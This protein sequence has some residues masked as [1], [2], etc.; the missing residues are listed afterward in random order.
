MSE[1]IDQTLTPIKAEPGQSSIPLLATK[2]YAPPP[3]PNLVPRI[4]LTR[5]LAEGLQLGC[6]LT[7]VS[8]PAGFG[9]TTLVTEWLNGQAREQGSKGAEENSLAL[10]S[11]HPSTLAQVAWLSLDDEDNDAIRFLTYLIAASQRLD[12]SIGQ[13]L[14]HSRQLPPSEALVTLLV[15]DLAAIPHTFALVLDDYHVIK[16]ALIHEI[17]ELLLRRQPPQMHLVIISRE[18]PPLP[19]SRWR[20]RGQIVEI[21]QEDLRF[22]A[23]ES[24]A[25]LNQAMGL[26][27]TAEAINAL[28]ARTEGWIAG[29]QLAGLSLQGRPAETIADFIDAFSG[30]HRYVID[31]LVEEVLQQ[32]PADIRRFLRQTA[33]LERLSAPLCNAVTEQTNSKEVLTALEHANLFLIPLDDHREWYR[34]H[35]LFAE[36]L[37]TELESP[38]QAPLH[39]KA[40]R[41]FESKGLLAEAIKHALSGQDIARA[42]RLI[43][44]AAEGLLHN[45]ELITLLGWLEA[46]PDDFVRLNSDLS[47]YRGWVLWLLGQIEAAAS[48]AEAAQA[49]LPKN[50]APLSR[51]KLMSLQACLIITRDVSGLNLAREALDLLENGDTFFRGMML[52]LLGDVQNVFG[53]TAGA[54]QTFQELLKVARQNNDRF[55]LVGALTNLAQQLNWQGKRNQA[56]ELCEQA[57]EE[58]L[59]SKGRPM[60]IAGLA[61]ISL[62]EMAYWANDLSLARQHLEKGL[63]LSEQLGLLGGTIAGKLTLSWLLHAQGNT[64]QALDAAQEVHQITIEGNFDLYVGVTA[65]LVA[66]FQMRLGNTA[67]IERWAAGIEVPDVDVF[68]SFGEYEYLIYA[69][70]LLSTGKV[71]TAYTLLLKLEHSARHA[72]R[73]LMLILNYLLQTITFDRLNR[74]QDALTVLEKAIR[75]AEPENYLRPFLVRGDSITR[76]LP[77]VR[78][79]APHFVD[80]LLEAFRNTPAITNNLPGTTEQSETQNSAKGTQAKFKTQH[81]TFKIQNSKFKIQ[82]SLIEPLSEREI[83]VLQLVADGQSN[84]E[85]A[86]NL[87]VTVGT[88]KKHLNNIYGKLEVK[89]RTQ[90]VAKSRESGFIK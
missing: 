31:Y 80:N 86:E 19:L 40:S 4:R 2:L 36:F 58:C 44:Q 56:V 69:N 29:L 14:L 13:N 10:A 78:P 37:R 30:S 32:Q 43:E 15:N 57:I 54:T 70:Y 49:A 50:A 41:W 1:R 25:F 39:Q 83:E 68:P 16:T 77:H 75:L 38:Q 33:I 67:E 62:G 60:P 66:D 48:Y 84:R 63:E 23:V 6:K 24:A 21:R 47:I 11:L 8:A 3:R 20:V 59:D 27:L 18:D 64:Q 7:L 34:Y 73:N 42:G 17:V 81:S 82:N 55:M 90:A 28:E 72:G 51:G 52:L 85:I 79:A 61:Y 5:R 88:V 53:D 87:V 89:S 76:L 22:T 9:K 35:H 65:A 45:G 26:N 71:E 74:P 46:L 12:G